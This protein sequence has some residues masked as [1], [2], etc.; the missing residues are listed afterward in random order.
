VR[1][2]ETPASEIE[3]P[4][5]ES[6]GESLGD[7]DLKGPL[8]DHMLTAHEH[9]VDL[10]KVIWIKLPCLPE[11]LGQTLFVPKLQSNAVIL[12]PKIRGETSDSVLNLFLI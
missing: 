10:Q 6:S 3:N 9:L 7:S 8:R 5:G 1:T 2:I 11:E 4:S 12:V